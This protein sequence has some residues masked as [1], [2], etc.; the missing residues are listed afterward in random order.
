MR[1]PDINEYF[2]SKVSESKVS[3]CLEWRISDKSR[4]YGRIVIDGKA[5]GSHR[6]S[7]FLTQGAIPEGLFVCHACDNKLCVNP[8]HLYLGD[9]RENQKDAFAK[10]ILKPINP[11]IGKTHCRNGHKYDEDN[12]YYKPKNGHRDC[13]KCQYQ[14]SKNY[15][16][17]RRL[18]YA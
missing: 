6:A 1:R 15:Q 4:Q 17:K 10:G 7:W 18:A 14:R 5:Y 11:H 2:W 16:T 13:K 9:N 8:G 12:T 3:D